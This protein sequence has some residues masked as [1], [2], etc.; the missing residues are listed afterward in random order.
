[1][2]SK[3]TKQRVSRRPGWSV[4]FIGKKAQR[5]MSDT[6]ID[7]ARPELLRELAESARSVGTWSLALSGMYWAR[8][9]RIPPAI[10]RAID[11]LDH[12]SASVDVYHEK[13]VPRAEAWTSP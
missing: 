9:P 7:F 2:A 1:M 10:R 8:A 11:A 5:R 12:F 4:Q 13:E 6:L 3:K